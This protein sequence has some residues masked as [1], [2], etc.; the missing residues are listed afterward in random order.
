MSRVEKRI[1]AKNKKKGYK[2]FLKF[3]FILLMI[4]IMGACLFEIDKNATLMFGEVE[5]Y[6]LNVFI[7]NLGSSLTKTLSGLYRE[8]DQLSNLIS[9]KGYLKR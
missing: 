6:N 8:I 2:I 1:E 9:Q 3:T 7:N 4:F 5:N